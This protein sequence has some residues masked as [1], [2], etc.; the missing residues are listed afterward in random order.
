MLAAI[1][2]IILVPRSTIVQRYEGLGVV[3]CVLACGIFL[4]RRVLRLMA[5]EDKLEEEQ[6]KH[7]HAIASASPSNTVGSQPGSTAPS[8]EADEA[9]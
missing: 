6:L 1:A 2:A 7:K 3:V 4:V 8:P 5:E 9:R